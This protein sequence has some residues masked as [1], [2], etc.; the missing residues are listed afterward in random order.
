MLHILSNSPYNISMS[1]L[2]SFS[3][4]F[5]DLICI[6]DGV[7]LSLVNNDNSKKI[8]DNFNLV[9]FLQDDLSARGLLTIAKKKRLILSNYQS[10]VYLTAGHKSNM[11]W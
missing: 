5:D 7:I 6:Q 8:Y 3:S 1:S 2:L 10:F 4:V 11:T 9:Y